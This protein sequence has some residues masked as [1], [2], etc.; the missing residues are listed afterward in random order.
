MSR[1]LKNY[2]ALDFALGLALVWIVLELLEQ[3][4]AIVSPLAFLRRCWEAWGAGAAQ[5]SLTLGYTAGALLLVV[6]YWQRKRARRSAPVIPTYA[7]EDFRRAARAFEY[8][9]KR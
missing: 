8:I 5:L 2:A 6:R 1:N 7:P 4:G 3:T 9:A